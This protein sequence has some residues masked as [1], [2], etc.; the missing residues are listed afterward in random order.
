[1]KIMAIL[2][3]VGMVGGVYPKTMQITGMDRETDIV[4]CT[5]SVGFQWEF[6]GCEDYYVGDYVSAIMYDNNT[7]NVFDDEIIEVRYS[8]YTDW[9][10]YAD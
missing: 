2:A 9:E 6:Y 7:Q 4:T 5:D 1:M 3:L 8:G 10:Q